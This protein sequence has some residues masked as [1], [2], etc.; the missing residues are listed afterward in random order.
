MNPG[1]IL[2]HRNTLLSLYLAF[3]FSVLFYS[4]NNNKNYILQIQSKSQKYYLLIVFTLLPSI[5]CITILFYITS[6]IFLH[7]TLC[8]TT[9]WW[10]WGHKEFYFVL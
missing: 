3:L 9:T 6:L 5:D 4:E 7:E 2:I 10:S 1:P 8:L